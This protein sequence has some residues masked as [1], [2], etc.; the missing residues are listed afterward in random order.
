M[1]HLKLF[2]FGAFALL[3]TVTLR[4]I[5]LVFLTDYKTGFYKEGMEG[6]GTGLMALLIA[7]IAVAGALIFILDA[8]KLS[9][10]PSSML[11]GSA[12]LFAGLANIAEPFLS[13]I[14]L[15]ALPALFLG[16]RIILILAAGVCLCFLGVSMLLGKKI[17]AELTIV[18]I[19]SWGVRLMTSFIC[20]SKMSN[21]SENLYDVL[22]LVFT[23]VFLLFFGKAVCGVRESKT[24]KVLVATG[25]SAVLFSAISAFPYIIASFTSKALIAHTPLDSHV[26]SI[27]MAFFISVYLVEIC[28]TEAEE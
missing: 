8:Q 5:Q 14:S 2:I 1:K 17:K 25:T 18:L 22:M 16:I 11:L 27:F 21:I 13:G 4:T 3:S 6:L 24:H 23:L 26:T 12:M 20:F 9:P 7:I 15:S 19:I 28:R 10:R